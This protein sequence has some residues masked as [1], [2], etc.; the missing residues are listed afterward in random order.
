M[1]IIPD[2]GFYACWRDSRHRGRNFARIIKALINCSWE[3]ANRLAG[4][5]TT[6]EDGDDLDAM[7]DALFEDEVA[8]DKE[9]GGASSLALLKEFKEITA[10]GLTSSYY[11]YLLGRGFIHVPL[12][13][14]KYEIYCCHVGEWKKRLLFPIYY[15]EQLVTWVGRSLYPG[16]TLS[17]K[18]L[19]IAKSVRHA[20]YCLYDFDSLLNGGKILMVSEGLMD[21]LKLDFYSP[22]GFRATCLFTKTMTDEQMYLILELAKHYKEVW[23]VLDRDAEAQSLEI[24]AELSAF[25]KN[26]KFKDLPSGIDDPGE[27][28]PA[29]VVKFCINNI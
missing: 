13:V 16:A 7:V 2:K 22:R 5:E 6:L 23:F 9:L 1:G 24:V 18:D 14:K 20:K 19:E 12:I 25:Q 17:Y 4:K 29:G 11:Q 15:K 26:I 10:R 21:A 28:S 3:E 8:E 27:M